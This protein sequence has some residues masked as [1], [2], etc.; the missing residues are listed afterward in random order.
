M[1]GYAGCPAARASRP[2]G[3]SGPARLQIFFAHLERPGIFAA[4]GDGYDIPG[5]E[6]GPTTLLK[7]LDAK[8][9]HTR[10]DDV[11]CRLPKED[12][13]CYLAS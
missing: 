11:G 5:C 6:V 1:G 2:D 3:D 4:P 10:V 8:L 13:A 7:L 9:F 12:Y